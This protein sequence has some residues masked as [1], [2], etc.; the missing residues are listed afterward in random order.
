MAT[1]VE[2]IWAQLH[3]AD[4]NGKSLR[5]HLIQPLWGEI[6]PRDLTA[7]RPAHNK[8]RDRRVVTA[9]VATLFNWIF[10]DSVLQVIEPNSDPHD[11]TDDNGIISDDDVSVDNLSIP[12]TIIPRA[13]KYYSFHHEEYRI[14]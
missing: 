12:S 6:L 14:A 9:Y 8:T 1:Y 4:S 7:V 3:T 11:N 13:P 5:K 10:P 2:F